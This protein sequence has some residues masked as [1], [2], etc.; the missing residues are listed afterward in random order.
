[1]LYFYQTLVS[2]VTFSD[3]TDRSVLEV[4]VGELN[5]NFFHTIKSYIDGRCS[6]IIDAQYGMIR[7]EAFFY[8]LDIA[9]SNVPLLHG[10]SLGAYIFDSCKN[11]N[12]AVICSVAD[13]DSVIANIGPENSNSV[14]IGSL[15]Y[16]SFSPQV[17]LITYGSPGEM[18]QDQVQYSNL[19]QT[20]P[21]GTYMVD[22]LTDI[23][24]FHNWTFVAVLYS[25]TNVGSDFPAFRSAAEKKGV[26]IK[27]S[28]STTKSLNDK[29]FDGALKSLKKQ[30]LIQVVYLL[31]T[32]AE[33]KALF[34]YLSKHQAD[35]SN[36]Q[37]I[38][39][40]QLGT[41]LSLLSGN[42]TVDLGL[43]TLEVES[44]HLPGFKDYFLSLRPEK[45][46]RNSFFA[47]FWEQVFNCSLENNGTGTRHPC[48]GNE[49]LSEGRGYYDNVP[50][51][52]VIDAVLAVSHALSQAFDERC[53]HLTGSDRATCLSSTNITQSEYNDTFLQDTI[54]AKLPFV[55]FS[56]LPGRRFRFDSN[57]RQILNYSIYNTQLVNYKVTFVKAGTWLYN[58]TYSDPRFQHRDR[59]LIN[60]SRIKWRTNS[61]PVSRCGNECGEIEIKIY[62]RAF[63]CCWTCQSCGQNSFVEN[64]T[65]TTCSQWTRSDPVA[66]KCISM[67]VR[68]IE[69]SDAL[70]VAIIVFLALYSLVVVVILAIYLW[71]FK[72]RAIKSTSR[73]L[74]LVSLFGVV[75][76]FS[77]PISFLAK[78]SSFVCSVQQCLLGLS[79]T[80]CCVPLFLKTFVIYRILK[81]A[82]ISTV[83][84]R[85][86][87]KRSQI[88]I[89]AGLVTIQI[90]LCALWIQGNPGTVKMYT[91]A[92]NTHIITHCKYDVFSL[93]INFAYPCVIMI[94]ASVFG[95]RTATRKLPVVVSEGKRVALASALICLLVFLYLIT[96]TVYF[97]DRNSFVQEYSISIVYIIIGAI[98]I[99]LIFLPRVC[100]VLRPSPTVRQSHCQS[101]GSNAE[102]Q[103]TINFS[104][105][106]IIELKQ[107]KDPQSIQA[108]CPHCNCMN[109]VVLR[110]PVSKT[111]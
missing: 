8:A 95:L 45:N 61:T 66:K 13:S 57:R 28:V 48:L 12:K 94:L 83:A 53:S 25:H 108:K 67:P 47:E 1:M 42:E 73:E 3:C 96:F 38:G 104:A 74:S 71:H 33:A 34:V 29:F 9:N 19:F 110:V 40:Q 89:C 39:G 106:Q 105:I 20:I 60:S 88:F 17:A 4:Q 64:N 31:L 6:G 103:H 100:R 51:L 98:S 21:S 93:T 75:L 26:C 99:S 59:L 82:K 27:Y 77:T 10:H 37:F 24:V 85:L 70:P 50:V 18:L 86:S 7:L 91:S 46:S 52:P 69:M 5:I 15:I 36:L 56:F 78:P 16:S 65:C 109:D 11:P 79:L 68:T 102:E 76:T 92:D 63:P 32:D 84:P 14:R 81:K 111:D 2:L 97:S 72:S 101:I 30:T 58:S 80:L 55:Q 23:A 43:I 107:T 90:L 35:F 41:K 54:I 62:D 44:P 49:T 87:R 22:A